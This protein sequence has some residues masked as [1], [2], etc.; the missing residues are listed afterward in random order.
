VKHKAE[1]L[2]A[3]TVDAVSTTLAVKLRRYSVAVQHMRLKW[4]AER[5]TLAHLAPHF[6]ESLL[7]SLAQDFSA[8]AGHAVATKP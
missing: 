8:V 2:I 5:D 3:V 6:R 4:A 1:A 7:K